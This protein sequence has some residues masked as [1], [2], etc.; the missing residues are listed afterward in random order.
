MNFTKSFTCRYFLY[1][2][3]VISLYAVVQESGTESSAS[4]VV[5]APHQTG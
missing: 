3:N 5:A 1:I 4:V 2:H